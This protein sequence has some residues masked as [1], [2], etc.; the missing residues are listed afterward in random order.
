M[1]VVRLWFYYT[2]TD[3][4]NWYAAVGE[5]NSCRESD[6]KFYGAFSPVKY[7]LPFS[8]SFSLSYCLCLSLSL[9][10]KQNN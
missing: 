10:V 6:R 5:R 8:I 9:S 7:S 3:G 1:W 2:I 4:V